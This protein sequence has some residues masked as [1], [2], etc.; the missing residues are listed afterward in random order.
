MEKAEVCGLRFLAGRRKEYEEEADVHGH[1]YDSRTGVRVFYRPA[2]RDLYSQPMTSMLDASWEKALKYILAYLFRP[3]KIKKTS[4]KLG[5]PW[6][7]DSVFQRVERKS[8]HYAPKVLR[9]YEHV[10]YKKV[11]KSLLFQ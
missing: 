9:K 4:R 11:E 7:H 2:M 8:N 5:R 6:I 1:L 10:K 3:S